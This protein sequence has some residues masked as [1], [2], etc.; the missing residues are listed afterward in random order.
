MTNFFWSQ[1]NDTKN[2]IVIVV[3]Y[4]LKLVIHDKFFLV[5]I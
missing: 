2:F 4:L 1:F 3:L 5:T